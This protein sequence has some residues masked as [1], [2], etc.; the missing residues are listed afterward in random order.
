MVLCDAVSYCWSLK[1]FLYF[2]GESVIGI[3][4]GQND[5]IFHRHAHA[6]NLY[7][8]LYVINNFV[9]FTSRSSLEVHKSHFYLVDESQN[10]CVWHVE[11]NITI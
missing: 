6:G 9:P 4:V 11:D 8:Q 1:R 2:V 3:R 10:Y 7:K 5:Y